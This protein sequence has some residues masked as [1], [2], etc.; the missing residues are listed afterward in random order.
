MA[1]KKKQTEGR[2]GLGGLR[3]VSAHGDGYWNDRYMD[4]EPRQ[5]V[6]P[7]GMVMPHTA[8]TEAPAE[9][10]PEPVKDDPAI[11]AANKK[12]LMKRNIK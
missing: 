7:S 8:N 1:R 4:S 10:A 5:Y 6:P 2:I 12:D 9:S 11:E 3:V